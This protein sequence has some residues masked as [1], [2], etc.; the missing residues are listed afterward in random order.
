VCT[1]IKFCGCK[2]Y[3][4]VVLALGAGADAFGM[5]FA[6]SPQR[7]SWEEAERI[8]ERLE[9]EITPVAVFVDPTRDEIRRVRELFPECAIQLSGNET[10]AFTKSIS[11]TVIKALHVGDQTPSEMD[12]VCDRYAPA[13]PLF[14]TK[15]A[16]KFGGTGTSFDWQN[17][18]RLARWRP[19]FVAGGLTPQNVGTCV[20]IV[21]PFAVD[22]RSGIETKGRKDPAKMRTFVQAVRRHDAA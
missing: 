10:P 13:L 3:E 6:P 9:G 18:A 1:R 14:D 11:G 12:R 22:V 21:R 15:A 8:A 19:V 2:S 5:I 20:R 17:I 4:D 7:I 16:G